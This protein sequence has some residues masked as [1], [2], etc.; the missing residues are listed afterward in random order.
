ML[1][2]SF[3]LFFL[4]VFSNLL[5]FSLLERDPSPCRASSDDQMEVD[6]EEEATDSKG[7]KAA[8]LS[9][10]GDGI[11]VEPLSSWSMQRE[12]GSFYW[13]SRSCSQAKLQGDVGLAW[14]DGPVRSTE[15]CIV[16]FPLRWHS[17][18]PAKIGP[19]CLFYGNGSS[20]DLDDLE[21]YVEMCRPEVNQKICMTLQ[22]CGGH[23]KCSPSSSPCEDS[24]LLKSHVQAFTV[25][26]ASCEPIVL[27]LV[28]P[29]HSH[30]S[31]CRTLSIPS[32]SAPGTN[33][34]NYYT[35]C[36]DRLAL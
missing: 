25:F 1:S 28:A 13:P 22:Q 3:S 5:S 10:Y 32:S 34:L 12:G 27:I 15:E 16:W 7:K 9:S 18:K 33:D 21:S 8:K 4:F 20:G 36:R 31:P 35:H 24:I 17:Q 6:E 29:I 23:V 2:F 11:A 26:E 19:G 14:T 30:L